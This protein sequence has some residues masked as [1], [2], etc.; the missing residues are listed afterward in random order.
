EIDVSVSMHDEDIVLT[1]SDNGCGIGASSL[2]N[3]FEPFVQDPQSIGHNGMG[4]GIG[5]GLTVVRALVEAHGGRVVARSAGRGLGSQFV[6]TLPLKGSSS[7][8]PDEGAGA[9]RQEPVQ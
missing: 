4:M 2:R 9:G 5:I 8:R 7:P 3:I 6:V 1:V